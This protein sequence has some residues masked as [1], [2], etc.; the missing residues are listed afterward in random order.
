[1]VNAGQLSTHTSTTHDHQEFVYGVSVATEG[2]LLPEQLRELQGM[3]KDSN[4]N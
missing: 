3:Y 1:M 4:T 2:T